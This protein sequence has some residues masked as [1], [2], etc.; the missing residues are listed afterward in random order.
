[1]NQEILL[2]DLP[3][4]ED[5]LEWGGELKRLIHRVENCP[6]PHVLGIHGNWGSGKTSFMRQLQY[7]LGG[8]CEDDGSIKKGQVARKQK[9]KKAIATVWFDSW[10]YQHE[11]TPVVAL[12][13]E[14]RRQ[15]AI[16]PAVKEKFLKFSEIALRYTLD[17][18]SDVGKAIGIEALPS[19]EKIQKIGEAWESRHHAQALNTDSIRK[20]LHETIVSLLPNGERSRIVVFIDDLDRCNPKAAIRLLEGLKIYLNL[21]NCVFVIGMNESVVLDAIRDEISAPSNATPQEMHLHASHYLEK[22][23]TDVYRLPL[24]DNS[25]AL[26]SKLLSASV[27][28]E[29]VNA[30]NLCVGNTVCLPPNPRRLKALANQW[31]RFSGCIAFPSTVEEQKIWAARV[32]VAAYIHQFHRDIWERW[33]HNLDFWGDFLAWCNGERSFAPNGA[34]MTPSWAQALKLTTRVSN[35]GAGGAPAWALQYPNPGDID[36]FWVDELIREYRD[37]L[38]PI[39]FQGLLSGK[40]I[41]KKV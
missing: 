7:G 30:F 11:P 24:P 1:M 20:H 15:L 26:F 35:A 4:L 5:K 25:T 18:L 16:M 41:V 10:R 17:G 29:Y 21:P 39:D 2:D 3:T 27:S 23:C 12:L 28:V 37:H 34:V 31:A 19:G 38:R 8:E 6:T 13:Q 9:A 32:I 36:V 22:I 14:M 33:H 40:Q